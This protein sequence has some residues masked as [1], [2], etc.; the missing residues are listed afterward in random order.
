MV[1]GQ[2]RPRHGQ[3]LSAAPGATKVRTVGSDVPGSGS[4]SGPFDCRGAAAGL[5]GARKWSCSRRS[6]SSWPSR[7][8]R[9]RD[10]RLEIRDGSDRH[11]SVGH[12]VGVLGGIG[13]A[14]SRRH[15]AG[16]GGRNSRNIPL[17]G[18]ATGL[19][20]VALRPVIRPFDPTTSVPGKSRP[21]PWPLP[22][23]SASRCP[24]SESRAR[25]VIVFPSAGVG[26]GTRYETRYCPKLCRCSVCPRAVRSMTW[27]VLSQDR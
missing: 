19:S 22:P 25:C 15:P 10:G 26:Q 24:A 27:V 7:R 17:I 23:G 2:R 16:T 20:L 4:G 8:C 21:P 12:V 1:R 3:V 5:L 18:L 13:P 11:R 6:R 14:L 9:S